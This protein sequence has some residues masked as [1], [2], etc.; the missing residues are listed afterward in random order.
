M[1]VFIYGL[2]VIY[3]Y[4]LLGFAFYRELFDSTDGLYCTTV[5]QCTMTFLHRGFIKGIMEV[6]RCQLLVVVVVSVV[7]VVQSGHHA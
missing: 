1:W 6:G 3:I 2:I 7:V 5:Y 4:A